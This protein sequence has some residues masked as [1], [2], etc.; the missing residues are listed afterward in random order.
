MGDLRHPVHI[1]DITGHVT[2]GGDG[3]ELHLGVLRELALDLVV[4]HPAGGVAFGDDDLAAVAPGEQVRVMLQAGGEDHIIGGG[5]DGVGQ[6]VDTVGGVGCV[7]AGPLPIIGVQAHELQHLAAGFLVDAV[8]DGGLLGEAPVHGP[9]GEHGAVHCIEHR[10]E[11]WCGCGIVE[12]DGHHLPAGFPVLFGLQL[13][14]LLNTHHILADVVNGV[15]DGLGFCGRSRG[16]RLGYR[17]RFRLRDECGILLLRTCG[18]CG[19]C[20]GHRRECP[21]FQGF[22]SVDSFHGTSFSSTTDPSPA[23]FTFVNLGCHLLDAAHPVVDG[24]LG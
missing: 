5:D 4:I 16:L 21:Q 19:E 3:H 11:G 14:F 9:V 1:G 20:R 18:Q 6:A 24:R 10:P 2:G 15:M 7:E 22:T 8:G 23:A 13:H 17:S 12:A